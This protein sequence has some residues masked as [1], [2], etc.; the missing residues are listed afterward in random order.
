MS[1]SIHIRV[2]NG[3]SVIKTLVGL[4]ISFLLVMVSI[5]ILFE[6]KVVNKIKCF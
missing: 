6:M 1:L 4:S 2:P 3:K 5:M